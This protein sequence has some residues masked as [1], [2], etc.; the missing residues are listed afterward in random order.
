[1]NPI[2][3]ICRCTPK[4]KYLIV[5]F[6]FCAFFE[7]LRMNDSESKNL[8]YE[9]GKMWKNIEKKYFG[10]RREKSSIC[11]ILKIDFLFRKKMVGIILKLG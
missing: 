6:E 9:E 1:M 5:A 2:Y 4:A 7:Y 11:Q 10:E 8:N 3:R